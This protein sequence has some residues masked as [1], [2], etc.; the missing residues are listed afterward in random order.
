VA[1]CRGLPEC[2]TDAE[3]R[4]PGVVAVCVDAGKRTARCAE[5]P[6]VKVDLT[7]VE[8]GEAVYSPSARIVESLGVFFPG[9]RET[10]VDFRSPEGAALAARY[11]LQRLPGYVM[12]REALKERDVKS[13][14]EALVPTEGMLVIEPNLAGSHQDITRRRVPG[15]AD[16]FLAPHASAAAEALEEALDLLDRGEA[17]PLRLR[18]AA[19]RDRDWKLAAQGGLAETEAMLRE[20]AV[21]EL[22]PGKL[23]TFLRARSQR[24][25]SSYWRDPLREAGLDPEGI[26]RASESEWARAIL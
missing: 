20:I 7:V 25:G 6:A 5:Y 3:C 9:I 12:G 11:R 17:P 14:V 10:K 2:F 23:V 16:L 15:R 8:D 26:R 13:I 22:H 4:K 19:F 21:G 18:A 24:V 1:L